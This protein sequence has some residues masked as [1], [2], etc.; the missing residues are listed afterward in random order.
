[1]NERQ[2]ISQNHWPDYLDEV[3]A[4]NRGRLISVDIIGRSDVSPEHADKQ[5]PMNLSPVR[6]PITKAPFFSL[7]YDPLKKG[8]AITITTGEDAVDYEHAVDAP[9]ELR[10]N[11][12]PDGRLDSLE[13]LDQ[14]GTRT[15]INYF[16]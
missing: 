11:L 16:D 10:A 8:N 9:V 12:D 15:K 1:M 6:V 13:I 5:A 2:E 3:T 4:G 7:A 14:N